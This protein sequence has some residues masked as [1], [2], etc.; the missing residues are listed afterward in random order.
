M[1]TLQA[2]HPYPPPP[3]QEAK[4]GMLS[5]VCSQGITRLT[6]HMVNAKLVYCYAQAEDSNIFKTVVAFDCRGI[7][8]VDFSPRVSVINGMSCV[9][10]IPLMCQML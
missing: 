4:K 10:P 5:R 7:E 8:P 2:H 3:S 6:V 9:C 1:V